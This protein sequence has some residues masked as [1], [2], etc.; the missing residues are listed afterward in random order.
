M[1]SSRVQGLEKMVQDMEDKM[2]RLEAA[3]KKEVAIWEQQAKMFL[4]DK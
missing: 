3:H 1:L 2:V 4:K